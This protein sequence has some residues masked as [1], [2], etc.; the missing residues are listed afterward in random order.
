MRSERNH[1]LM[2]QHLCQSFLAVIRLRSLLQRARMNTG[3]FIYPSDT[4][5]I[6]FD[7]HTVMELH[8]W[9]FLPTQRVSH[10][11]IYFLL[12]NWLLLA[13]KEHV[14]DV[15]FWKFHHQLVHTPLA[16]IL[17]PLKVAMEVPEVTQFPGGH[18]HQAIYSLGPYITNYPKQ[19]LLACIVQDW[20]AK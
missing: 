8:Y 3:P 1:P 18:F 7:E 9:T 2:E 12:T 11:F 5:T 4:F 10:L 19:A 13:S 20:C 17:A 15:L 14:D 6:M 16:K